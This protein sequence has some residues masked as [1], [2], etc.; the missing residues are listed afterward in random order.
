MARIL[1]ITA[2]FIAFWQ[3]NGVQHKVQMGDGA[4]TIWRAFWQKCIYCFM[5]RILTI[6]AVF[7]AL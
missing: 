6:T 1:T 7:I 4:A 3:K 5:A 2:V